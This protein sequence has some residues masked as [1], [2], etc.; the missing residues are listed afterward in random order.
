MLFF[1]I[2]SQN[3]WIT[4][5]SMALALIGII[6][7]LILYFKGKRK[8]S[9]KYYFEG[10]SLFEDFVEKINGLS[11]QFSGKQIKTLTVTKIVFWNSGTETINREDFPTNDT[12]YIKIEDEYEILDVSIIRYNNH[13]NNIGIILSDDGKKISIDFEYLDTEDGF[14]IQIFHTSTKYYSKF[15]INGSLKG[16]GKLS[17][18]EVTNKSTLN[19][20]SIFI[21]LLCFYAVFGITIWLFFNVNINNILRVVTISLLGLMVLS[22]IF[23]IKRTFKIPKELQKYFNYKYRKRRFYQLT[24]IYDKEI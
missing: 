9:I 3:P 7:T 4:L 16:F 5:V 12:F 19:L 15:S 11:I 20:I 10:D 1:N 13:A 24:K 6:L 14:V 18:G 22:F 2:L 8:K 17:E 23:M 21:F